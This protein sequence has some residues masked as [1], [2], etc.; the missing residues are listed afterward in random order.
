MRKRRSAMVRLERNNQ[1]TSREFVYD[2]V[3]DNYRKAYAEATKGFIPEAWIAGSAMPAVM[4]SFLT[5]QWFYYSMTGFLIGI[6]AGIFLTVCAGGFL[7]FRERAAA[8]Y[9]A[10]K[11]RE[12][13]KG[14]T[15]SFTEEGILLRYTSGA[16][17][18]YPYGSI[19]KAVETDSSITLCTG[20][21]ELVLSRIFLKKEAADIL[22]EELIKRC[23]ERYEAEMEEKEDLF[24]VED[25]GTGRWLDEKKF[26]RYA[27]YC[28][29][30]RSEHFGL[31][32]L[33]CASAT[34]LAGLICWNGSWGRGILAV[35]LV[36]VFCFAFLL[37]ALIYRRT[38]RRL[39]KAHLSGKPRPGRLIASSGVVSY[40][41]D[42]GAVQILIS[43]KTLIRETEDFFVVRNL[44]LAK[45]P[46]NEEVINRMRKMYRDGGLCR[47]E[48]VKIDEP[49][50]CGL[51]RNLLPYLGA[52]IF[53][54]VFLSIYARVMP[55]LGYAYC[56]TPDG[57][58]RRMERFLEDLSGRTER[59]RTEVDFDIYVG[60]QEKTSEEAAGWKTGLDSLS[61]KEEER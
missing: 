39:K 3:P 45:S 1:E 52:L 40:A 23:P 17:E 11:I 43:R 22:R 19:Q 32:I 53:S 8:S 51:R 7:W 28:L 21:K 48:Y 34:L 13:D 24:V 31:I 12:E 5:A 27:R 26:L 36:C 56:F 30:F 20:E 44:V 14:F 9:W 25:D 42:R 29:R 18:L 35:A 58:D 15:G 60:Q 50:I 47:Y 2:T 37:R 54:T 33:Y 46:E 55:D 41:S 16:E 59:D 49:G 61:Q 6:F 57:K 4:L 38:V 10:E